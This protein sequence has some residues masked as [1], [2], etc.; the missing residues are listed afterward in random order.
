MSQNG[1]GR[2]TLHDERLAI[3]AAV[4][5]M[6]AG[7][8]FDWHVHD[9]HQLAWASN[10]VL[11]VVTD[12]STWVL[13]P[14]RALWIPAGVGHETKSSGVA[15]MRTLYFRPGRAPIKWSEP[16]PV[17]AGALL[18]ELIGHLGSSALDVEAR[19]HAEA[20]IFDLLS[21]LTSATI[22]VKLPKD[23]RAFD[24]ARALMDNPADTRDLADWGREVGASARTLARVFMET[25]VP[26]GRWRTMVR[27]Q[28][29]APALAAGQP[30]SR[31]AR[32]VGYAT[33][34]AFI[35]AFRRETGL[36]PAVYFKERRDIPDPKGALP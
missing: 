34:S 32:A 12:R 16:T 25:G 2:S 21:P 14:T 22:E 24:V 31:V 8:V 33:T 30:V 7:A 5:P 27:M 1:Q 13:P 29:A 18:A 10:G 9:D 19:L 28:A 11:T 36:T 17:A 35:A 20:V 23:V 4:F 6:D 3:D 26:F 15:T